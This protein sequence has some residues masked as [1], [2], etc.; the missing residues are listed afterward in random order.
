MGYKIEYKKS[1]VSD[2]K[3]IDKKQL[4]RIINNIEKKLKH[5][6]QLGKALTGEFKGLYRMRIGSYRVI[7]TPLE[8][9]IIILRVAH[10]KESY[11]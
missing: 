9:T 2:L 7:Y 6:P 10:R 5:S 8:K 4:K 3:R 11:R 1:V